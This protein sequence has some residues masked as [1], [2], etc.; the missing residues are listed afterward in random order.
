MAGT[1]ALVFFIL[2]PVV[3][4]VLE[5]LL[6]RGAN[7]TASRDLAS[8]GAP[9]PA[10]RMY[11]LLAYGAVPLV[12]GLLLWLI[13]RP[14]TSKIDSPVTPGSA[15]LQPLVLWA[16]IAYGTAVMVTMVARAAIVRTRYLGIMGSDFGRV[17]PLWVIPFSGTIFALLLVFFLLGAVDGFLSG[18]TVFGSTD[19]DAVVA[20]LQAYSVATLG[21]LAGAFASNRIRDLSLRGFQR[22]LGFAVAGEFPA[23]L[24]LVWAFLAIARL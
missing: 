10:G 19:V 6:I 7:E 22:A 1:E 11:V 8:R 5:V 24:G 20:A 16:A 2:V 17:L 9:P 18:S 23:V 13:S 15:L 14:L 12:L 4:W 3:A 21:Y